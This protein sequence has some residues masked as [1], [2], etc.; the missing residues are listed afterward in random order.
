MTVDR[1]PRTRHERRAPN[2]AWIRAATRREHEGARRSRAERGLHAPTDV[3]LLMDVLSPELVLVDPV[4]AAG[5]RRMLPDPPDCLVPRP[6]PLMGPALAAAEPAQTVATR[7]Q[8]IVLAPSVSTGRASQAPAAQTSRNEPHGWVVATPR[9]PIVAPVKPRASIPTPVEPRGA[10][11]S[12]AVAIPA[13][14]RRWR[15]SFQAVLVA[16]LIAVVVGAPA[17]DLNPWDKGPSL[18][19][20]RDEAPDGTSG[21]EAL[22]TPPVEG[23]ADVTLRWPRAKGADFYNVVL[24]RSGRRVRD[25]WPRTNR[26][27]LAGGATSNGRKLAPGRY[28]WFVFAAFQEGGKTRFGHSLANG[29][30]RIGEVSGQSSES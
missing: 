15:P 11:P 9:K 7:R 3:E 19:E 12:P 27:Q 26:L 2:P 1:G 13:H 17:F 22:G 8:A 24:W 14:W 10:A 23:T 28:Q 20:T 6:R 25:L 30:F 18:A 29:V 16:L 4:L 5:A 21:G